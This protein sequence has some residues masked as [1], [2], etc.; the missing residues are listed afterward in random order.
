MT[1]N[2]LTN[3][4]W[5]AEH[6]KKIKDKA[7]PRYSAELNIDLPIAQIFD[8]LGRTNEFYISVRSHFGNLN[9][10]F[11]RVR[12]TIDNKEIQG[13]YKAFRQEVSAL[14]SLLVQI[15]RYDTRPIPWNKI[16]K[17]TSKAIDLCW[18]IMDQLRDEKHRL[19]KEKSDNEAGRPVLQDLDTELH[20]LYE[21]Q[22]ELK[23]FEELSNSTMGKLTNSPFLLL[24]GIAGS[25][26]THLVCDHIKNRFEKEKPLPAILTFGEHFID[27]KDVFQQIADQ[28][29]IKQTGQQLL[30]SLDNA[31]KSRKSRALIIIDALNETKARNFWK[32]HLS[33]IVDEIKKYPNVGLVVSLR[34]GF[35]QDIITKKEA[36]TFIQEGHQGFQFREWEAISKFFYEFNLP[37][38]EIPLL[39]PEF[40]NPLFLLLFCKAFQNRKAKGKSKQI[41]KGHEG[42]TYI[43]ESFVDSVS[44]KIMKQFGIVRSGDN[45]IWD[46]V[47]EK[48]AEEMVKS[49]AESISEAQ[50]RVIVQTAFPNINLNAFIQELERNLLVVKVPRYS[51]QKHDYDG[52]DFRFPFQ[53]FSDNLIGRYLFKK[54]EKEFGKTNKNPQTA[55]KF[56]S[57]RRKLG[58]FLFRSWN[59]GVVEALS[60]QCPEHLNGTEF[61]EV[62]PYFRDNHMASEAFVESLVWRKP[63]AFSQDRKN[64]LDYIN[65]MV[66]R[67]KSGHD[68]LLNAFLS[69]TPIPNHPFNADFLHKH[70]LKFSMA[71]RDKWWSTFLHYQYGARGSVDR[72]VEWG[73]S[74]QD[75]T[76][77]DDESIR[78]CSVALAWFLTTPNRYL[79]DK[80][81]KA[82]VSILT[83][84][85]QVAQKI[86]EQ[87]RDVN[88]PYVA[89]RL[90]AVA[91]GVALRSRTNKNGLKLLATWIYRNIFQDE[92]VPAHILL[93]DYA[94]GVIHVALDEG[95]KLNLNRKKIAPPFK[96]KWSRKIPSAKT[97]KKK[98]YPEDF[99]KDKTQDR[100]FL[101][102]WSSVMHDFGT[103]GDFGNYVL[104]TNVH[105]WSGRRL[106]GQDVNRKKL[107]EK[108]KKKLPPKQRKLFEKATNPFW[109]IDFS[110]LIESLEIKVQRGVLEDNSELNV[111]AEKQ[112]KTV[113]NAM[114]S[115]EFS[116]S[117]YT[118]SFFRKE[119]KPYLDDRGYIKDPL[120]RFDT[121]LAQ[122]W[123]FNKVVELG[124]QPSLHGE[125]DNLVNYSRGDRS[126]HKAE[127]IGK[128]YQW[129][130]LHELLA[131]ISDNFEF[132]EDSW[133]EETERFEGSWQLSVRDIDPSCILKDIPNQPPSILP[134][135][136]HYKKQAF[137]NAWSKKSTHYSWLKKTN[138]LP[139]PAEI[140]E[141]TDSEGNKW[142][143]LEG[144]VEW[145]EATPPEQEKYDMATRQLWYM[146]RSYLVK[147]ENKSKTIRWMRRQNF[148]GRWML[149]S[150]EFYNVYLSEYPWSPAFLTQNTP[151]Y[152]HDGW[153]DKA[154]GNEK[155]P[156]KIL[157][158]DDTYLSS[159]SS[160]DCST[161]GTITVKLPAKYVIDKMK[162]TQPYVDGRFFDSDN[163]L[164][165]FDPSVFSSDIPRFVF[166]RKNKL[167]A[168]LKSKGYSIIWTLLGE[169]NIVGGSMFIPPE[170]WMEINGVY[171]LANNVIS[172]SLQ[173][174][175]SK[176]KNPVT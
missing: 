116:L 81:T 98:Y 7:G 170:G 175:F 149:E 137:Y 171:T 131:R 2:R 59:R 44:K 30:Q 19:E 121:G 174:S 102:I 112:A 45:S 53:K 153:T 56:F 146:L 99:F 95:I 39:M 71:E 164:V 20:H 83:G 91:Y 142:V 122:R 93:R 140:I 138:D 57:K 105:H 72:L 106:K 159:G 94:C 148:M 176:A 97:L 31:G 70:L 34:S 12:A 110:K 154:R 144:S 85:P 73:W 52:F 145:Q 5:L 80:S 36:K 17:K 67:S 21:S 11:G 40:Q 107:L 123:V 162:L 114:Q 47:I 68:N 108:F 65:S 1:T 55:K 87:F 9:R 139:N 103:L 8:G 117:P 25:G 50:L 86:L 35:E 58:K 51:A 46:R 136:T 92:K 113:I 173:S 111:Q 41:F 43:F 128:K 134:K 18:H 48:I 101:N 156:S 127:R 28:A 23:Y 24:T 163:K 60:I 157:V 119:I 74:S 82:L 160:I 155:M 120:E 135:L 172:G 37:L 62:A 69:V 10:Q 76:H 133:S 147:S 38:P 32:K 26:K 104:N 3:K 16:R 88:D 29:N 150:H 15:K 61:I 126:D 141:T 96:S 168:F 143:A 64:T 77:L 167:V 129:I 79:R 66:M 124:W 118:K 158:T 49:N 132:K 63:D 161:D 22:K 90:Y 130:A 100:G 151:Y 152:G 6:L 33:Q 84:R 4:K 14:S 75:K 13:K 125:F 169:K 166:I 115:F 109:G 78:L 89:E 54:Y 165:A 42:A 27:S